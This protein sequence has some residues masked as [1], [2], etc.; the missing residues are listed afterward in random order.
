MSTFKATVILLALFAGCATP[1]PSLRPAPA[2]DRLGDTP[3]E[4]LAALPVPDPAADPENQDRRFGIQSARARDEEA[5]RQ[6][7]ERRRCVDVISRAEAQKAKPPCPPV[8][9]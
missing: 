1:R 9:K 3:A 4:K 7:E 8:K 6:R 2:R 5:R